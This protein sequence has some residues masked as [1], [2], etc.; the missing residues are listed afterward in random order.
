MEVWKDIPGY[1]GLYKVSSLGRVWATERTRT[2]GSNSLLVKYPAGVRSAQQTG[3][4]KDIKL[5]KNG[6]AK[7]YKVHRLVAL[8][9]CPNP[10]DKP[11]VDHINGITTDNRA[12]NLR[13][14]TQKENRNNPNT[15]DKAR[16]K[17]LADTNSKNK[18]VVCVET[19]KVFIGIARAER[20]TG[21]RHIGCV[22]RGTRKTAGGVHWKFI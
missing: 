11:Q 19:G 4:Y 8:A 20:E 7:R 15:R 17:L 14:V 18:K 21:F 16:I 2:M 9:F 22:C 5:S 12:S 10:E 3:T 1:E 13:W 6:V